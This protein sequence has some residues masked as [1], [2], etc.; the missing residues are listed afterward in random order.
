MRTI[1]TSGV[2]LQYPDVISFCFNPFLLIATGTSVTA[3][4]VSITYG[5]ENQ[6]V[7]YDA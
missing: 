4:A 6:S 5:S 2:T 3:M 1:I 7:S